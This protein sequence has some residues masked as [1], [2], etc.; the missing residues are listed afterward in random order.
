V[1]IRRVAFIGFRQPADIGFASH[2]KPLGQC[3]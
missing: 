2:F 1:V 3:T